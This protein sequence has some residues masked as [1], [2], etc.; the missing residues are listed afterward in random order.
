MKLLLEI[1]S[2]GVC[3][4]IALITYIILLSLITTAFNPYAVLLYLFFGIY[5]ALKGIIILPVVSLII[6]LFVLDNMLK[7]VRFKISIIFWVLIYFVIGFVITRAVYGT[8]P[9]FIISG[10][11]TSIIYIMY[12]QGYHKLNLKLKDFDIEEQF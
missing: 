10:I 3:S 6:D 5:M 7:K 4:F 2:R 9:F 1:S 12:L 8:E 11:I